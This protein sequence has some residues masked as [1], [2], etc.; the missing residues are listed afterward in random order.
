MPLSE[1]GLLVN[2]KR[3]VTILIPLVIVGVGFVPPSPYPGSATASIATDTGYDRVANSIERFANN[4]SSCNITVLSYHAAT[5]RY[6][7][8][9]IDRLTVVDATPQNIGTNEGRK[10]FEVYENRI[11]SGEIDF[12]VDRE[13]N[14]RLR[15]T[16]FYDYVRA[17]G[18]RR[19]TIPQSPGSDRLVLYR[20]PEDN[21]AD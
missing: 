1:P 20:F 12:V 14:R 8:P 13:Q 6:Y 15:G 18:T 7:L 19:L 16:D 5:L 11:R 4:H 3:V 9:V 10:R 21:C 2:R 17:H